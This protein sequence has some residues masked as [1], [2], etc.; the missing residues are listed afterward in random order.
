MDTKELLKKVR[1]IEIKTR[2]LSNQMFSGEYHSAFKGRGMTFNEVREYAHGD[3][4][5]TIDWNV[6]ARFNEPHVKV[7]EEERELTVF[8]LVDASASTL[9]GTRSQTK[10][11][12]IIETCALLAFSAMNNNDKVGALFFS[13]QPEKFMPPQKGKKHVLRFIRDLI[14]FEPEHQQTDINKAIRYVSSMLKKRSIIFIVS[15]F[16]DTDFSTSLKIARGKHDIVALQVKDPKESEIPNIGLVQLHNPESGE[17]SWVNTSSKKTRKM[18]KAD[19]LK[20]DHQLKENLQK[21]GVDFT[22][23]ETGKTIVKPL[24]TLFKSR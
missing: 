4:I 21:S 14:E 24:M 9:F 22:T 6:T 3:E 11:E 20:R 15:D 19:A 23:L 13:N 18:I 5:R 12:V 8:F 17:K 2:G 10:K 1:K 7:F 16:L